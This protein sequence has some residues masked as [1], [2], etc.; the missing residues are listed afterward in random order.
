MTVIEAADAI[1]GGARTSELTLPGLLH[2]DCSAVH[3][4]AVGSPALAPLGLDRHGLE[5]AW[6][7][8]DLSHPF[9]GGEAATMLR[10]I[11]DTAAGLGEAGR[12][13]RRLFGALLGVA[14]TRSPR[15]SCRPM[16]HLPRHPLLLARF[17]LRAA[18]PAAALAR[19]LPTARRRGRSSRAPP[20]TPSARSPRRSAPRSGWR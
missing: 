18:A 14:S 17:G 13:W 7:E 8:V 9:D 1:G 3:A 4:L 10:S 5:W 12:A 15:T 16:L 6:P 2:D 11:E 20:P 19:V